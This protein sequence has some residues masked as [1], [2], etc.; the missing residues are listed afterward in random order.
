MKLRCLCRV[1]VVLTFFG[2]GHSG[3]AEDLGFPKR[4]VEL[5]N[6]PDG[7]V[8]WADIFSSKDSVLFHPESASGRGANGSSRS[9]IVWNTETGKWVARRQAMDAMPW[10][11]MFSPDGKFL[12]IP[13][14][15]QKG[16]VQLW[17][18]GSKDAQGIPHLQLLAE[19]RRPEVLRTE[20]AKHGKLKGDV[21]APLR[22]TPDSKTLIA[23]YNAPGCQILFW[24]YTDKPSVL[25]DAS[26]S[27]R[28]AKAW[29]PWAKLEF[30]VAVHFAVSPDNLTL[31][32]IEQLQVPAEGQL[33]DVQTAQPREKFKI[34]YA[35]KSSG[36]QVFFT[37]FSP[38]GKT[39]AINGDCYFALWDTAPPAPRFEMVAPDF[40]VNTQSP[41]S[42]TF[43]PDNRWCLTLKQQ[44]G[45][46]VKRQGGL[47]QVRD[48]QTGEVRHE[49]SFPEQ[50][51]VLHTITE[52]SGNRAITRL[53]SRNGGRTFL[54]HTEDLL[55]YALEHGTPPPP[56]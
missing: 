15:S 13:L 33:F 12:A 42:F 18:V 40:R 50:L 37:T 20:Q 14:H 44:R 19:L 21:Y 49:V 32:V 7:F 43:T 30:D 23:G 34:D 52:L 6:F 51:G 4:C 56:Q 27:D 36:S 54:W 29:K 5:Q 3:R 17:E 16:V 1:I 45:D 35:A 26:L 25:S 55:R 41:H 48:M 46:A 47:M 24:S 22:W 28:E 53:Y 2:Q 38:D 10:Y 9:F 39:L 8:F 11:W 31:A